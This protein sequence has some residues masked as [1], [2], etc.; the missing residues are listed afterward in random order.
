[1]TYAYRNRDQFARQTTIGKEVDAPRGCTCANC[2]SLRKHGKL[3]QFSIERDAGP[4]DYGYPDP[5]LFCSF[6]CRKAF[7]S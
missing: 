4:R 1:M 7:M 5:D 6:S 2:G 3:I